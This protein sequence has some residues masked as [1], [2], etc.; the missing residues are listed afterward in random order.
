MEHVKCFVCEDTEG[1]REDPICGRYSICGD[2]QCEED[3]R[4]HLQDMEE[5]TEEEQKERSIHHNPPFEDEGE[6]E[7]DLPF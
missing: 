5:E 1:L 3:L 7:D 6:Y 2:P 4:S